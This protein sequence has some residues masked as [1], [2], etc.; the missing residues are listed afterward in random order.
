VHVVAGMVTASASF[1]SEIGR[2]LGI[3]FKMTRTVVYFAEL[4]DI[5]HWE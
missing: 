4:T 5:S 1:S 2:L 3:T